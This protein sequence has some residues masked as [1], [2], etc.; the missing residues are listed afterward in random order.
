MSAPDFDPS[1]VV[2]RLADDAFPTA[3]IQQLC[4]D[5]KL[6]E[7]QARFVLLFFRNGRSAVRAYIDAYAVKVKA[8]GRWVRKSAAET[9][10]S[11][12]VRAVM[13]EI[14]NRILPKEVYE[15]AIQLAGITRERIMVELAKIGFANLDDY[16]TVQPDGTRVIDFSMATRDQMAAVQEITV[17]TYTEGHGEDAREVKRTKLKLHPK[18]E[19][20]I[21]MGKQ[22]GMFVDRRHVQVDVNDTPQA[23][24]QREEDR[25]QLL[26][27]A[28]DIEQRKLLDLKAASV[29]LSEPSS[30]NGTGGGN[31]SASTNGHGGTKH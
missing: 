4:A 18:R 13:A 9:L 29:E 8:D 22:I 24:A 7:R 12:R 11:P 31:G 3:A 2:G 5:R 14:E 19:A 10:R 27:L 25:Q 15:T 30:P 23:K 1:S 28:K 17:E 6:T 20:L 16:T 26:R 21:A